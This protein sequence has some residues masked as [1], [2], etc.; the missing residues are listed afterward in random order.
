MSVP[1][2][3]VFILGF[4]G[5]FAI[6]N[7]VIL[8]AEYFSVIIAMLMTAMLLDD[9]K[10]LHAL[11]GLLVLPLLIMKSLPVLV[12]LI[13]ILTVIWLVPDYK[14][15]LYTA[16]TTLP[17]VVGSLLLIIWYFPHFIT[18]FFLAGQLAHMTFNPVSMLIGSYRIFAYF[19]INWAVVPLYF[20]GAV[21]FL[22]V[23]ISTPRDYRTIFL[24]SAMW[25][26]A[27]VY[28]VIISE[29]FYYHFYLFL[30]PVILTTCYFLKSYHRPK[31]A[32]IGIV[33]VVLL[34]YVMLVAGWSYGLQNHEVTYWADRDVKV[35]QILTTYPDMLA[36]P[37]TL[38]FDS[39]AAAY[40]FPTQSACRY[41]GSLPIQRH[42]PAW[43]VSL[44]PAYQENLDCALAYTGKY[45]IVD[46]T[47]INVSSHASIKAKLDGEYSVGQN[48]F[49][50]IYRRVDVS[51]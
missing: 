5:L 25:L 29:Y 27:A 38:Y 11:A 35:S 39:G 10:W 37:A 51:P 28:A 22:L 1:F 13:V 16:A 3:H 4:L 45:V 30:L 7:F 18:D 43:N 15:R 6:N 24:I 44:V 34:I 12:V 8:S 20:V 47:W 23:L 9:R 26:V 41:V 21:A 50:V 48:Q 40:Y 36:Q 46:P 32:L 2:D 42:T 33:A 14:R 19:A 31:L 49:W 17:L